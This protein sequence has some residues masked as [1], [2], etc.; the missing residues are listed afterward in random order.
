[1]CIKLACR[2]FCCCVFGKG[3]QTSLFSF[4]APILTQACCC[5]CCLGETDACHCRWSSYLS[6]GS[7]I[8]LM[9]ICGVIVLFVRLHSVPWLSQMRLLFTAYLLLILWLAYLVI[10]TV[11]LATCLV[12]MCYGSADV[13]SNNMAVDTARCSVRDNVRVFSCDRTDIADSKG[14]CNIM[15]PTSL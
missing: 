8:I 2:C 14:H 1:M 6:T 9:G 12:F 7:V 11:A 10:G 4:L 13:K 3:C 5:T 15:R